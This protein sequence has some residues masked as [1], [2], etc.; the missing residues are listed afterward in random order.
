MGLAGA[1]LGLCASADAQMCAGLASFTRGPYQVFGTAGF[2]D[3][4]KSFA[5]GFGF[6]G[7][8]PFGQISIGTTNYDNIDG[9]SL[10]LGAG[11]GYQATLGQK[12]IVHLCPTASLGIAS[13]P[14][15]LDVFGDGSVVLDLH[16]TDLSFGL[17]LGVLASGSNPTEIIPMASL[18]FVSATAKA[19]DD[20]SGSSQ[21][22]T[23]TFGLL[24]LGLGFV[25]NR[26]VSFRPHVAIPI[27]LNGASTSFGATMSVNFGKPR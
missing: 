25:F 7:A 6:G 27:G 3:N 20:V 23:Q 16:E 21:S 14:N 11:G 26:V 13:G 10:L 12:G 18:A 5:G 8:G 17:A 1:F 24:E 4:A 9:S 2:N 15:N 22:D 19:S